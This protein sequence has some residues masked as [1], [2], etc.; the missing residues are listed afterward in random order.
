M[1]RTHLDLDDGLLDLAR[2]LY[3]GR[4]ESE[5]IEMALRQLV[6]AP[7]SREEALAM[8]GTG[9]DGDLDEMRAARTPPAP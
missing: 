2:R 8:K 9:W 3:P 6:E 5:L 4:S 7:L 1:A